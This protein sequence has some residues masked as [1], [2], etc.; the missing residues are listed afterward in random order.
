EIGDMSVTTQSKLLRVLQEKTIQRMGGKESFPVDVRIIAATHRDLEN[1]VEEKTFRRDL[2][3][4]LNVAVIRLPP[5]RE[6]LEDIPELVRYFLSRHGPE[7]GSSS[8]IITD[9][10]M[11][12]LSQQSWPGNVRELKNAVCKALVLA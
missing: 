10:A 1:A 7:L 6:R 5:L 3:Y 2:Y 11:Q 4:R 12:L 9:E 8:P